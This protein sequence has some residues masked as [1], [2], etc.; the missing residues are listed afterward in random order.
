MGSYYSTTK[1]TIAGN[2]VEVHKYGKGV[3]YNGLPRKK[4]KSERPPEVQKRMQVRS[5]E[6]SLY[7]ARKKV[8]QLVSSNAYFWYNSKTNKSYMPVFLTLTFKESVQSFI[9]A[10]KVFNLFIKRLNYE[11][12]GIKECMLKYLGVKEFQQRGAIHFHVIFFNL[13]HTKKDLVTE[14]WGQ[15]FVDIKGVTEKDN[16]VKYVTKYITK[17]GIDPRYYKKKRYF[18]SKGLHKPIVVK[19]QNAADDLVAVIPKEYLSH[20]GEQKIN[21]YRKHITV[22]RYELPKGKTLDDVVENFTQAMYDT[23]S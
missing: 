18:C 11:I 22:D 19:R 14:I 12:Y 4:K 10:G 9:E 23:L 20:K 5:L 1:V 3:E 21:V 13:P 15:G 8:T 6:T 17:Q 16:I 7:R 2:I